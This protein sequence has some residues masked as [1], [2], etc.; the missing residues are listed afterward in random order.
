MR[1][2]PTN[3][4]HVS[5]ISPGTLTAPTGKL[6]IGDSSVV[7]QGNRSDMVRSVLIDTTAD[8]YPVVA[9][10]AN[11][12]DGADVGFLEVWLSGSAPPPLPSGRR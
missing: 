11:Y 4:Q 2:T 1:P 7:L 10:V 3:L 12:T 6:A 9:R 5:V 8:T